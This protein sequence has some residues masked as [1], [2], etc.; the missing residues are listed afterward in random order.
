ME[1]KERILIKLEEFGHY[2]QEL[3]EM[4][5]SEL[6]DYLNNLTLRRACEKTAE[7][8]IETVISTISIMVS[9]LKLGVPTSEDSLVDLLVRNKVITNQLGG[10]IKAM[11][12]FRNILI[13]KYGEIDDKRAYD[14][15]QE[16]RE[17]FNLLITEVKSYIKN[18]NISL[19]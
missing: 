12:G 9:S 10:K 16:E 17:D 1:N 15:F 5:P 8:A 4:L 13:H 18:K 11:K 6:E 3:E 14:F 19:K 2:L 7:L